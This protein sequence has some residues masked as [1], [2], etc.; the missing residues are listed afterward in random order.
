[1]A[2]G[3]PRIGRV[4][5]LIGLLLFLAGAVLYV[6]SWIGLRGM[7]D[8]RR[9]QDAPAFAAVEHAD[10][11]ARLGRVGFAVMAAGAVVAVIAALVAWRAGRRRGPVA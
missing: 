7:D 1:M 6:R 3:V 10:A 2:T 8:F 5:D 4:L 9:A 11:L